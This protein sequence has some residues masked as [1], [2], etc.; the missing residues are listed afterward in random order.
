MIKRLLFAFFVGLFFLFLFKT[1]ISAETCSSDLMNLCKKYLGNPENKCCREKSCSSKCAVPLNIWE[2]CYA[3]ACC[4]RTFAPGCTYCW[5]GKCYCDIRYRYKY[6]KCSTADTCISDQEY[7]RPGI[8][9]STGCAV[10]GI[11][12]ACCSKA[13]DGTRCKCS[14]GKNTGTCFYGN[15]YGPG[16]TLTCPVACSCSWVNKNCGQG[17]CGSGQ[18]YQVYV[19]NYSSCSGN[20]NTRC[21]G[22]SSCSV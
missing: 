10:G 3:D 1:A 8:C 7:L 5:G 12:K 9:D 2:Y 14:G 15:C 13:Q 22:D 21:V 18:R 16:I 4:Y 6:E 20:G 17:G 19:C 11:Y